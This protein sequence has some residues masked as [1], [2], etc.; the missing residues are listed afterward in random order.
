MQRLIEENQ[1]LFQRKDQLRADCDQKEY[2]INQLREELSDK[3][4]ELEELKS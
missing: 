1:E 3:E 2:E 4:S